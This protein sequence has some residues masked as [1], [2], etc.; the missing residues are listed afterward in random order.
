MKRAATKKEKGKAAQMSETVDA[1]FQ[2]RARKIQSSKLYRLTKIQVYPILLHCNCCH[3]WS[4][5]F[6]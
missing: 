6:R 2:E 5:L 1:V 4:Y 3:P